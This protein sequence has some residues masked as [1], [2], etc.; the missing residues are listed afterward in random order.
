MGLIALTRLD[1]RDNDI[2]NLAPLSGLTGLTRLILSGNH[3]SDLTPLTGMT[4]LSELWLTHNNVSDLAPLVANDG[5]GE[6]D[7]VN[8]E[9]NPL[10]RVSI[11]AHG[12]AL[13]DRGV[14]VS[15]GNDCHDR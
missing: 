2:S 3:V 1:L 6:G 14:T 8:V 9:E 5:L 15:I 4:A 10:S 13:R 11:E 7:L 12:P